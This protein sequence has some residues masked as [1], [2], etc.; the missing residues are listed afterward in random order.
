[1]NQIHKKNRL[2]VLSALLFCINIQSTE[3]TQPDTTPADIEVS[4]CALSHKHNHHHHNINTN[5]NTNTGVEED[6]NGLLQLN[7][8]GLIDS[9]FG[10]GK[11]YV[12]SN[13]QGANSEARGVAIQQ[14]DK[15]V[16]VG[17]KGNKGVL[18]RYN[19]NG[20][21]DTTF[22]GTG[23]VINNNSISAFNTIAMQ[24]D[25]KIVA[26]GRSSTNK[27]A[28]A[29]YTATGALDTTFNGTGFIIT[30]ITGELNTIAIQED[31]KIVV[32]GYETYNG[33]GYTQVVLIRYNP[34]GSID[35]G[36][37][38]NGVVR[39]FAGTISRAHGITIQEDNKIV[40]VG[41]SNSD[42]QNNED[43]I[44]VARYHGASGNLDH[45]GFGEYGNRSGW[46]TFGIGNKNCAG[47][48]V[49]VQNNGRIIIVGTA[50]EIYNKYVFA[51]IG[52]HENGKID[53][54]FGGGIDGTV[55]LHAG[56]DAYN[57]NSYAR[58][59][60][61]DE[62]EKII[63]MGYTM[64]GP[65]NNIAIARFDRNGILDWSFGTR[66]IVNGLLID[67]NFN[68][69]KTTTPF[70]GGIQNNDNKLIVAGN[71]SASATTTDRQFAVARF[72]N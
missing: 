43:K 62:N 28:L 22:G 18:V 13:P 64:T 42:N 17:I 49:T 47:Y 40:I 56:S 51:M 26:A 25:N 5:D 57:D 44:L 48:G 29:R 35:T 30:T 21:F 45:T 52:L 7:N 68:G 27:C 15:I 32:A 11:G 33:S 8:D 24:S 55:T 36:F 58:S 72:L 9:T 12:I 39:T 16:V 60:V 3:T 31:G 61:L 69:N 23:T 71:Y 20:T 67:T 65:Y 37:G 6:G 4:Y 41:V 14:N 66:G 59:V 53:N 19:Q 10:N 46:I 50:I 34:N 38:T 63:I 54:G 1:M 70:V 2:Y